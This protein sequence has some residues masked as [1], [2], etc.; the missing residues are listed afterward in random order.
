MILRAGS[1]LL[2]RTPLMRRLLALVVLALP[3]RAQTFDLRVEVPFPEG[4]NLP[5]TLLRGT[6]QLASGTLDTGRGSILTLER[7]FLEWPVLRLSGGLEGT[8]FRTEG[9]LQEGSLTRPAQLRQSGLGVSLQAQFW[10]PF[11]GL[12]GELGL[13]QRF[14]RYKYEAAGIAETRDLSRTWLRVGARWRLP[15]PL[16]RPYLAASYQEPV[17]K[18]RPVRLSSAADLAGYLGA[19]GAGQEVQRLWTFGVGL[20]F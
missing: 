14:Q 11:T 7:S 8:D 5:Q 18:D 15:F 13:I 10:I 19:Q 12:A 3:L 4:Q 6:G 20:T 1:A 16:G 17:S 2:R 9:Q